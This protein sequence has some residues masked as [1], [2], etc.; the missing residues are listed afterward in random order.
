MADATCAAVSIGTLA[1]TAHVRYTHL[2]FPNTPV[3]RFIGIKS[4][5]TLQGVSLSVCQL[6]VLLG[7]EYALTKFGNTP[8]DSVENW[9]M[10]TPLLCLYRRAIWGK[11]RR[12]EINF[13]DPGRSGGQVE[14]AIKTAPRNHIHITYIAPAHVTAV[15]FATHLRMCVMAKLSWRPCC[16]ELHLRRV[17]DTCLHGADGSTLHA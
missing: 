10:D 17:K 8:R 2:P 16:Q 14:G 5:T 9:I 1:T 15:K 4:P 12:L 13:Q 7:G 6:S 11:S 3:T